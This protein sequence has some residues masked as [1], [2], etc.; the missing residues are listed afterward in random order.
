MSNPTHPFQ[1]TSDPNDLRRVTSA[2]TTV[3]SSSN[4][5]ADANDLN[6]SHGD[7]PDGVVAQ[8]DGRTEDTSQQGI[9]FAGNVEQQREIARRRLE[10][11]RRF[12]DLMDKISREVDIPLTDTLLDSSDDEDE[13]NF[14][15][16]MRQPIDKSQLTRQQRYRIGGIEYRALDML[17]YIVP[18]YYLGSIFVG[19]FVY[20]IFIACNSYTRDVLATSNPTGPVDPWLFSF[21][22]GMSGMNNLGV[23]M[24]DASMVPFQDTPL[25]LIVTMIQILIGNTAYAIVLRFIIWILWKTT[26]HRY[27]MRRE[28]FR[29]LL[30]HPRR[31]YTTLF[32]ATQTWWLLIILIVITLVE[33]IC[34]LALNYWLPVMEGIAWASRF[35]DGLFQSI[36]TRNAGFTVTS[37]SDLNPVAISMRN[38]NV[39]QE[40]A[41][42]IFRGDGDEEPVQ[43]TESELNGP[44]PFIKLRRHAT[45][46]SVMT[47]SRKVLRGPDF[48]VLNLIQRQLTSDICWVISGIFVISIIESQS[49][50]SPSPIT[51]FT[52]IYECVS[53]FGNVGASTGYP[54]SAVSQC[55]QYH[56]LSLPLA[57]DRAV[58]LPSEE[59]EQREV[60]DQMLKRR[61][62]SMT[63]QSNTS[64]IMFY[65]RS[66]TL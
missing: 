8:G 63:N 58:L 14:Q 19:A 6:Q 5:H 47:T 31:C 3:G 54:N 24:L 55:G 57:I 33:L 52:V 59:V 29:F 13:E 23:S 48:F 21:F 32:P 22:Q 62:T 10:Q 12:E 65:T 1:Q 27:A 53:A 9:A 60:E 2:T 18:I 37:L 34:Y 15:E 39:Y 46:N 38:S 20:R 25:P 50:M 42:G 11:D 43:F 7:S 49:I 45:I 51:M 64:N 36:A 16:I 56:T 28:T 44:A 41:L 30:D 40:R 66:S 61:N 35:V 26:P 4:S 17:S